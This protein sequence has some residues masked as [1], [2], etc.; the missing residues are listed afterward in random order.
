MNISTI[1][2]KSPNLKTEIT[3]MFKSVKWDF[4]IWKYCYI[5]QKKVPYKFFIL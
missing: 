1:Y 4:C 3:L 5:E 2:D